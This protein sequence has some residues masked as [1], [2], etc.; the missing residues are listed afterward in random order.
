MRSTIG[1]F[2]VTVVRDSASAELLGQL[3]NDAERQAVAEAADRPETSTLLV[4]Q[5][6]KLAG[7]AIFGRDD[8]GMVAIYAARA[9]D[10]TGFLAKAAITGLFGAAQVLGHP[11]R[12]HAETLDARLR[13]TAR[14]MG[15]QSVVSALD[16]D[17]I[18]QGIFDGLK[19]DQVF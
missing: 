12:F 5:G 8:S 1:G 18:P 14:M 15:A 16:A 3:G 9:L 2:V 13:A 10:R 4:R 11:L 19:T 6:D 17:G 7:Y